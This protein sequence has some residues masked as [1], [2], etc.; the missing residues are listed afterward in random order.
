MR[1]NADVWADAAADVIQATGAVV[2]LLTWGGRLRAANDALITLV[3]ANEITADSTVE[4][5]IVPR[6]VPNFRRALLM[7]GRGQQFDPQEF[8]VAAADGTPRAIAWS[9]TPT[10]DPAVLA[11]V[12][13]DVTATRNEFEVLRSRAVTDALTGLPNRAGLLEHMYGMRG[14]GAS[15]IFCDLNGFKAVND[16]LG[17]A[18]G[19]AVLVEVARRLKRTVRGDD[20]VAR[21]GGDEFVVVAPPDPAANFDIFARR[22]LRTMD[23]PMTLPG[24]LVASVGMSIGAGV[25]DVGADVESVLATADSNMYLMKSRLPTRA[26]APTA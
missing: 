4:S 5:I 10:A 7:I 13:V 20:F 14:S 1:E 19:D 18:V 3:G 21:L 8:C 9:I 22:L 24:G 11:A 15:V 12:G 26:M 25:L 6:D 2:M 23:Q 17:H 16:T